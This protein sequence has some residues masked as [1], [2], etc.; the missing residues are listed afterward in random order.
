VVFGKNSGGAIEL[1]AVVEGTGGF[2][3][4]GQYAGDGSGSS[5]SVA[6]DVNGDGL[7]D[8]IVGAPGANSN[9]GRSYVVFG[10]STGVAINL[11]AVAAGS[12]GFVING[13]A[14]TSVSGTSVSAAGDVNGDG[15]ADLIVGAPFTNSG[16]GRSFVIFG[17]T[18]GAFNQTAVDQ[19]G[20]A[21]NDSLTDNGN[22]QT[23]VAGAGNDTLSATAASVLYGG[24]GNDAFNIDATM[25]AAL[26]SPM[27]SGGNTTKLAR[28]DGGGGLDTIV[29]SGAGLTLDLTQ[30]ANQAASNPDGGSRIDSI[31]KI[32]LTGSGDNTLKLHLFDVLD[33]GS[34]NLFQATGRQQ[35]LVKGDAG[36]TVNL[37]DGT[38]TTGW[39][40]GSAA[41]ID[42]V[43]YAVWNHDTSLATVYVQT[44]VVV[45]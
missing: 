14:T 32:D 8:L 12:G 18:S 33:L 10:K 28:I 9:G 6:G 4:N 13:D 24:A 21:G 26:Q 23:L 7:A 40:A 43:S 35:L 20:G 37:A 3:I 1:T 39:T 11:S 25:I 15:L 41:T 31:E 38:G 19:L 17:G 30:V 34:A 22:A 45:V 44:G 2:V 27:G 36:D 42:T 29:L 16:A 5:V